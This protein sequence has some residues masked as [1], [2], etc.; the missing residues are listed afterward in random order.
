MRALL[1][2]SDALAAHAI[3]R[4]LQ[5]S[6]I[7]TDQAHS[8]QE[9]LQ[10]ARRREYD[11]ILIDPMLTD[12]DG[13]DLLDRVQAASSAPLLALSASERARARAKAFRLGANDCIDKP[14]GRVELVARVKA[15]AS[16][17]VPSPLP[18]P[19]QGRLLEIAP[20]AA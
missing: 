8:S 13:R 18:R 3:E 16:G 1:I 17:R 14:F 5:S 19:A 20:T 2:D 4:M 10:L 11:V 9:A 7:L 12:V 15:L 6:G